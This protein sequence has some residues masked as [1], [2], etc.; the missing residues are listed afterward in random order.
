MLIANDARFYGYYKRTAK[1]VEELK[2]KNAIEIG[3]SVP[4][5]CF[6]FIEKNRKNSNLSVDNQR[7]LSEGLEQT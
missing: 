1:T 2:V 6:P 3:P 7:R 5:S 4:Q